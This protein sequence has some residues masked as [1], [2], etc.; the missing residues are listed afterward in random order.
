MW[1]HIPRSLLSACVPVEEESTLPSTLSLEAATAASVTVNAKVIPPQYWQRAWKKDSYLKRLSGM[2]QQL[3]QANSIVEKWL[4][5]MPATV[6]NP[7]LRRGSDLEI[8]TPGTSGHTSCAT[9]ASS[10]Q[11]GASLRMSADTSPSALNRSGETFADLV[12]RL[13]LDY[14]VRRKSVR[15]TSENGSTSWPTPSKSDPEGSRTLPPG[16]TP[17]GMRPDGKKA[18][19]GLNNAVKM[20]PTPRHEG[21]DAGGH[22]GK[23]DLLHSA[24]KGI[25]LD[26]ASRLV[27]Q[28]AA[29]LNP[30]FVENLM[31]LPYG[32]TDI[33][34]PPDLARFS[35]PTKPQE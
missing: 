9:S 21:F 20:W 25:T 24:V 31:G 35:S 29:L 6:V 16:T 1:I 23:N 22:R 19:V 28:G 8:K 7:S 34:G 26:E 2:T 30:A 12:T 13:K 33:S 3:F 27:E 32:W 4:S 11:S 14:S 18:Q 5:S 17:T 15:R 10:N